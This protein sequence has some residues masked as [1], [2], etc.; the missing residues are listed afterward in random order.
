MT[1]CYVLLLGFAVSIDGFVAGIA[2]GLKKIIIP[3]ISLFIIGIATTLCTGF[4]M[5]TAYL[6]GAYINTK[7]A[8]I[9]GAFLLTAMGLYSMIQEYLKAIN[10]DKDHP[11][12]AVVT[13]Q[14]QSKSYSA[15]Q[16]LITIINKP[17]SADVDHSQTIS[18]LEAILL[19]LAL[20]ADNMIAIFAAV[21]VSP[22]P[23]YT[24]LSMGL[25]QIVVITLGIY[26]SNHLIS[27]QLKKR[28][29]YLS[30]FILIL[31]GLIRLL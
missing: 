22:L 26:V 4:A 18:P 21:L 1:L 24:P 12:R 30:G 2:Y 27:D 19:G 8:I 13:S 15:S 6:L 9:V 29:P 23:L 7:I 11:L 3:T 20:G 16:L 14:S 5:G 28:V 17:E 10:K 31:L 25:I